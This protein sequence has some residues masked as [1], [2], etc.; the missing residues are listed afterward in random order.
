VIAHGVREDD[1]CELD[2]E[3]LGETFDPAVCTLG[4][5]AAAA[6]PSRRSRSSAM[7]S[8]TWYQPQAR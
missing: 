1:V 3:R 2:G 8:W 7:S 4:R 5:L 6:M